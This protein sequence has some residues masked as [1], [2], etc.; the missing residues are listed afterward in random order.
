MGKREETLCTPITS[1]STSPLG[2]K[3]WISYNSR[4]LCLSEQSLLETLLYSFNV[5]DRLSRASYS[6]QFLPCCFVIG[7][8][9]WS[10]PCQMTFPLGPKGNSCQNPLYKKTAIPH[11]SFL[12]K[13]LISEPRHPSARLFLLLLF[14]K[15]PR[16]VYYSMPFSNKELPRY[17]AFIR[18]G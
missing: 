10:L 6:K 11:A 14:I 2:F 12:L 4:V 7:H 18:I 5:L 1:C 13:P 17:C 9:S 3:H 16:D 15:D 8:Y